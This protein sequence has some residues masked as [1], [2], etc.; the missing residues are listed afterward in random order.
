[1]RL[2]FGPKMETLVRGMDA[3]ERVLK[4]RGDADVGKE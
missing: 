1:M 2:S 4:K 3:I